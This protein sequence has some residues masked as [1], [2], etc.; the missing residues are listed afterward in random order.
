MLKYNKETLL[1]LG[2]PDLPFNEPA[3]LNAIATISNDYTLGTLLGMDDATM[4]EIQK[5]PVNEQKQRLVARW[6]AVA[7]PQNCNWK[8]L[9]EAID[10]MKV[11]EWND[12]K[13]FT[14][15][16]SIESTTSLIT[17]TSKNS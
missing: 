13:S 9:N 8:K 5:H 7:E 11:S 3:V 4:N 15:T 16:A 6:F 1:F 14:S 2:G 12:R 10:K 17:T